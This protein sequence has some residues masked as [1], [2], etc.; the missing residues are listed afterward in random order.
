[1]WYCLHSLASYYVCI[2]LCLVFVYLFIKANSLN[3]YLIQVLLMGF[4]FVFIAI[5]LFISLLVF[6]LLK[7]VTSIKCL[8]AIWHW[9]RYTLL[10][11]Q[12]KIQ[13]QTATTDENKMYLNEK[14]GEQKSWKQI[15]WKKVTENVTEVSRM[16]AFD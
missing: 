1:M 4:H 8:Q 15:N 3:W 16:H 2:A 11:I 9:W 7:H 10:K 13:K 12:N 6:I 5:K 14:S